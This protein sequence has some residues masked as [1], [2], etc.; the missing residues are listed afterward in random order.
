[1]GSRKWI[2][3]NI[4]EILPNRS[5]KVLTSNGNIIVRNRK[6]LRVCP[7]ASNYNPAENQDSKRP[8]HEAKRTRYGRIIKSPDRLDLK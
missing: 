2:A 1:M 7:T 3:G 6:D 5:Y 4:V 8:L